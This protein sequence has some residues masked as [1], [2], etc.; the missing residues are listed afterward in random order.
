MRPVTK[1]PAPTSRV[2]TDMAI[3]FKPVMLFE[4]VMFFKPEVFLE[5][6]V[7]PVMM[8]VVPSDRGN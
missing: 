7:T 1:W 6:V 3:A 5:V 4:P 2:G 8:T